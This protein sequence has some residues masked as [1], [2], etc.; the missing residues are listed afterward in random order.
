MRE[1]AAQES[2]R[3]VW[4]QESVQGNLG[5]RRVCE[6]ISRMGCIGKLESRRGA[7]EIGEQDK[8]Q[9][10]DEEQDRVQ[11]KLGS[12]MGFSRSWGAGRS[13]VGS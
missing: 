5:S 3:E 10:E 7:E 9:G 6:G 12:R 11:E 13:A 4:E 1:T 2:G 8:V